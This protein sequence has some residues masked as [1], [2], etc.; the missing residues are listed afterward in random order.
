VNEV[1]FDYCGL[2]LDETKTC[3]FINPLHRFTKQGFI[4][5]VWIATNRYLYGVVYGPRDEGKKKKKPVW[6]IGL[7]KWE[8]GSCFEE[9]T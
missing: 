2:L 5:L 9:L 1:T 4:R 6:P 7:F 8:L 3:L